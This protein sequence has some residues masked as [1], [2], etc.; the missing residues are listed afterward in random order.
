VKK[1]KGDCLCVRRQVCVHQGPSA[2]KRG[3]RKAVS[4]PERKK[5]KGREGPAVLRISQQGR[6]MAKK[7]GGVL[8]I[9]PKKKEKILPLMDASSDWA[10]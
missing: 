7:E 9:H 1:K 3:E 4:H 2:A 5:G 10:F 8:V 6:A